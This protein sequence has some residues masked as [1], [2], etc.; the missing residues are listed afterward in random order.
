MFPNNNPDFQLYL[1]H[2]RAAELRREAAEYRFSR[3]VS[4]AGR[5]ARSGRRSR[6]SHARA[7]RAPA[8]G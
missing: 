1:A 2:E 8:V 6:N 7:V 3:S 5:H 4:S